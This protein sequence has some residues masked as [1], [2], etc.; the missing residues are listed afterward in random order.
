MKKYIILFT[1]SII[2][3]STLNAVSSQGDTIHIITHYKQK[4]ITDPSEGF[5]E[6]DSWS[7]FPPEDIKYRKALLSITYQCPDS[8]R[9]GEWDYIDNIYLRRKGSVNNV[10]LDIELARMISPYGSRFTPDW[11]F[12]WNSDITDFSFLLHDSVEIEFN[13]TGYESNTDRGWVITI[14]FELTEGTPSMEVI[15]YEKLW[16]GSFPYGNKN[17]D[18]ENYLKPVTFKNENADIARLRILQTG[19]GMDD[20]ENCAEF[21]KKYRKIFFDN[22]LIDRRDIWKECADN[23]LYPQAGTWIF[24]RANWC[25]GAIVIPDIYDFE[26]NQKSEHSIDIEMEPYINPDKPAANYVFSSYLF[27]YKKPVLENDVSIEKIIAPSDEDIYSRIN[28]ISEFPKIKIKNNGS[29]NLKELKIKFGIDGADTLIFDWQG[30]LLTNETAEITVSGLKHKTEKKSEFIVTLLNPNEFEDE[31]IYDNSKTSVMI[32]PQIFDPKIILTIKTNNA[33]SQNFYQLKHN[34]GFIL[35]Q[36]AP[37]LLENDK[38]YKDTIRLPKGSYEFIFGDTADNGLDFWFSPE[39]GYGYVR[40]TDIN[41]KLIK[42]Y[43]SDFGKE[44][45]QQFIVTGDSIVKEDKTPILNIFPI[46]NPGKFF[47][48]IFLNE[49]QNISLQITTEDKKKVVYKKKLNNF[50]EGI[51]DIDISKVK[52]GFYFVNV[53]SSNKT[54]SKKMKVKRDS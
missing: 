15:G 52:D 41:G 16:T 27:Y 17:D 18:I 31:Y 8:Q 47:C 22:E 21:C 3:F 37:G 36:K 7:N 32:L 11:K 2:L 20:L 51:V 34:K 4:V 6:Y 19:H 48:D 39:E 12:T 42:A 13:H 26:I 43:N 30:N 25:P 1:I 9:C 53:I 40:I 5:N 24:D 33:A 45:R 28:P 38:V 46:R 44:I 10:S 50:K 54:V 49:K 29:S 23:P 35:R 14:D